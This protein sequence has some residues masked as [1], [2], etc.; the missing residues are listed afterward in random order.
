[1]ILL[2]AE[3]ALQN[4]DLRKAELLAAQAMGL[5]PS[6]QNDPRAKSLLHTI[7]SKKIKIKLNRAVLVRA[8]AA[9][10][11]RLSFSE[12]SGEL[13]IIE[14]N[15]TGSIVNLDTGE[16]LYG[17]SKERCLPPSYHKEKKKR[18]LVSSMLP[19]KYGKVRLAFDASEDGKNAAAI[20]IKTMGTPPQCTLRLYSKET[21]PAEW[22]TDLEL[23]YT[24]DDTLHFLSDGKT[25]LMTRRMAKIST[26]LVV[27]FS[28]WNVPERKLLREFDIMG[29]PLVNYF[30]FYVAPDEKGALI[31][32]KI[33]DGPRNSLPEITK[34]EYFY[35][36][37][38]TGRK[39]KALRKEP[40]ELKIHFDVKLS[41]KLRFS[42]VDRQIVYIKDPYTVALTPLHP[43][44]KET[45]AVNDFN[46]PADFAVS[47]D[48]L[49]LAVAG[50]EGK[51]TVYIY[52]LE[53]DLQYP[54]ELQ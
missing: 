14:K 6:M 30:K 2:E 34:Y 36:D 52:K 23:F 22:S 8:V 29:G 26:S 20:D 4:N 9:D 10:A 16:M 42:G 50:G 32:Y 24:T 43:G 11:G 1:M 45:E 19:S 47:P 7:Q 39:T 49:F 41:N 13:L 37:F 25:L 53:W 28:F 38:K 54:K 17:L 48:G 21:S 3:E 18:E 12:D 27:R 5:D 31:E 44:E 40:K 15:D 35:V 46:I 33:P 51:N